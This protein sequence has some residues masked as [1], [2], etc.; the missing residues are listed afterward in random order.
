[1][2]ICL[3]LLLPARRYA[4]AVLGQVK[5]TINILVGTNHISRTA[6]ATVVK[7]CIQVGYIK[8]QHMD[9]KSLLKGAWLGSR[10]PF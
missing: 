3:T 1:M 5:W 7:F 4:S 6:A 10:D 2:F 9:D 8:S